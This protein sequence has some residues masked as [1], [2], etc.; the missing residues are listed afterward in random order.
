MTEDRRVA[1]IGL[2]YVGLPLAIS[3][4]DAGLDVTGIDASASRV[5]ALAGGT[6]PIDDISDERLQAALA[7][8]LRVLANDAADPGLAD[9]VFVCVPTPI[10]AAKDPDLSP[11]VAAAGYLAGHLRAGQL[12][13]LQSTT[14]PGTTVGPFREILEQSGL[15]AGVDF[16]LAFAPERVNPG[17]P[18][19][20]AKAVPRLVGATTPQ[21]VRRAAALLATIN[22]HV[23]ELSSPDAAEMAKLLENVFR[24]VNIALVN[25]LALLCERMGLDVWEVIGAAATKPFGFMRFTPGPGVGGHCIPVDPY[26]LAWRAREFDFIDRFV[27]LAGDINLAM[28]RHVVELIVRGSQ[29]PWSRAVRVACRRAR[30]GVQAG[31]PRRPELAG[32]RRAGRPRRTRR[33]RLVPRPVRRGLHRRRRRDA[34]IPLPR[35]PPRGQRRGGRRDRP[36]R[37]RLGPGLRDGRPRHRHRGQLAWPSHPGAPGAPARR[38]VVN[39]A[40]TS[41][42]VR[43]VCMVV[44]SYYDEDPRVRREAE[45]LVAHG[46]PVD[47]FALRRP[48]DEP[49]AVVEGVSVRRLDVQRHQG[50][51]FLVY[52][53]E[54]LSF[55]VLAC[56]AVC[57][58]HPRRHYAVVQVASL[59]DFLV[60]AALPLKLVGVPVILDLHEAMTEMFATRF[61]SLERPLLRRILELQERVSAAVAD[62]VLTVNEAMEARKLRM[63]VPR[64]RLDVVANSPDLERFDA[65]RQRH[66][67]FR[68]DGSLRVIY[69]GALTPTYE[70][71]VAVDA[72]ALLARQRPD[73]DVRFDIYGRGDTEP[74]L[75]AQAEAAGIGERVTFHGRV[76]FDEVPPAVAASDIGLAPTRRDRYTD[77]T[78]STKNFEYGAMRKPVVASWLP[79]IES[80]F[81]T[82]K[83]VTYSSGHADELAAGIIGLADDAVE[84]EA[85]VA[86]MAERVAE[87]GWAR[88]A[89]HY[90][91]I[92]ERLAA[93]RATA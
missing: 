93:R 13:I 39:A 61:P 72:I 66:R 70:V 84:R 85:R 63:G 78:I 69:T 73:L 67:P 62:Q 53:L 58:A 82:D 91:A 52:L 88:E 45:A 43:P 19:S 90:V 71:E 75:R 79:L 37:D 38:R 23:L 31:R 7:T 81:G 9:A 24:N 40:V 89:E 30:G 21:G 47:V 87:L 2:G 86:R 15:R 16:D 20:M 11:V 42:A 1:V 57:R 80:T 49:A 46:R 35:R 51:G 22:D 32:G 34:R 68:E 77:S 8:H 54:Y 14:Y 48:E 17:D 44:H 55:L 3:F 83:V 56:F 12:V 36:R 26:Y 74:A 41:R 18:D 65:S 50:A 28:P 59:P 33:D 92:V 4:V 64:D 60:F 29:R 25:Q 10:T 5:A 76:P 27:E 6:S